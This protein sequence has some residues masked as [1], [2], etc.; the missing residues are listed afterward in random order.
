[1]AHRKRLK[2]PAEVRAEFARKGISISA[3]AREHKCSRTLVSELLAG[4]EKRR[5]V[6]GQSHRIAVL[7][8]LKAG[9]IVDSPSAVNA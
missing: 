8:G 4:S 3:W 2:K 7:L 1:M 5:C 9:E 6:R